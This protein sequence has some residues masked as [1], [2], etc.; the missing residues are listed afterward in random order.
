MIP[1]ILHWNKDVSFKYNKSRD[2]PP[3]KPKII[4][5]TSTFFI[6]FFFYLSLPL[7]HKS[8]SLLIIK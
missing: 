1:P 2:V 7:K 4:V 8:I 5:E 3:I 6:T